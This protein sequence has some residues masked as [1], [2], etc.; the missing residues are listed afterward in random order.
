MGYQ[1]RIKK[2]GDRTASVWPEIAI[3]TLHPFG[4][5]DE[6]VTAGIRTCHLRAPP[7]KKLNA[8]ERRGRDRLEKLYTENV[9]EVEQG[10]AKQH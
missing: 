4:K 10:C 9:H 2:A 7:Q 1:D 5:Q 6:S 3:I 8:I